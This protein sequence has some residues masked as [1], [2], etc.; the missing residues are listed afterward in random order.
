MWD[1]TAEAYRNLWFHTGD[2]V[3][4]DADGWYYFVDR[5]KDTIRRRGENVSSY[6][7]EQTMLEHPAV[8]ECAAVSIKADEGGEDEIV[9]FV[10]TRVAGAPGG[11]GEVELRAWALQRLPKFALPRDVWLSNELPKTPSGKIKKAELRVEAKQRYSNSNKGK[12]A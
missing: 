2:G 7:I 12:A 9:L 5:L 1:R 11:I 10:V 6:E 3:R 4:R 8:I